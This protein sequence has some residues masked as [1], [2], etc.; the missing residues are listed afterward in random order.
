M[1][2]R[3]KEIKAGDSKELIVEAV[4]KMG[5]PGEGKQEENNR[6]EIIQP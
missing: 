1:K 2:L 5:F 3:G 4:A 6:E